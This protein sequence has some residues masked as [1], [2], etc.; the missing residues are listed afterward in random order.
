M[1]KKLLLATAVS[2]A[3]FVAHGAAAAVTGNQQDWSS[4]LTIVV[5][6][7]GVPLLTGVGSGVGELTFD[8]G[9]TFTIAAETTTDITGLGVAK[10]TTSVIYNGFITGT[11]FTT[12]GTTVVDTISCVPVPSPGGWDG[13][14]GNYIV[15][16]ASGTSPVFNLDICDGGVWSDTLVTGDPAGIETTTEIAKEAFPEN[17]FEFGPGCGP[18]PEPPTNLLAEPGDGQVTISFAPGADNGSPITGYRYIKDDGS[19][20]STILGTTGTNPFGIA[21]DAAGNVYTANTN[22]SD[23]SKITSDGTSTIIGLADGEVRGIALDADGNV[24][25]NNAIGNI[26][27]ITPDGVSSIL[28]TQNFTNSYGVVIDAAGNFYVANEVNS[29]SKI[30]PDGSSSFLGPTGESPRWIALDTAGNVYTPN[31]YSNNVSKITPAGIST[32]VGIAGINPQGIALDSVGN[33]YTTNAGSDTVSKI[34]L[35]GIS[36][37]LGT[38]GSNSNPDGIVIDAAGN[39][40]T[41]N[42]GNNNVSKITPDGTSSILG[43]TG[44]FP[45]KIALDADGNVYTANFG[46]SNVSKITPASAV[47]YPADGDTSPITITGLSNGTEYLISLIAVNAAGESVASNAVAVTPAPTAPDAPLITNIEPGNGQVSI[48][49]S[50]ADDGGSLI[51]GY[52]AYCFGDRLLFGA[53]PTSPIAVSG[54]TNGVSYTCAATATNDIGDSPASAFSA[55]VT[56]VAPPPGC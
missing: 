46:S 5:E 6:N 1:L 39:V 13:I 27:K 51:T 34:T 32:I 19:A 23:V 10:I 25:V 31:Y 50:M 56:P 44:N 15:G 55:P 12:D 52:N 11:T 7:A 20:T 3:V 2:A 54:L 38:T 43:T 47:T 26:S 17:P 40:Y 33:I 24:Y 9:G 29:V 22:S 49:V 41:A 18:T 36:T 4:V 35:N 30:T 8:D 53:S 37:T 28:G 14:C 42:S 48:S 45:I 21:V 16:V